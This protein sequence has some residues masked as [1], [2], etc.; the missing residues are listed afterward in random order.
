MGMLPSKLREGDLMAL[1]DELRFF[2]SHLIDMLGSN[3]EY[4]GKYSV[5]KGSDVQ[6]P[7]ETYEEALEAGYGRYGLVPFL[8]KKL[9]R[10]GSILYFSRPL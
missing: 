10:D 3:G 4:E 2:R 7:F 9:E 6:G 8:V 5:I 1:D